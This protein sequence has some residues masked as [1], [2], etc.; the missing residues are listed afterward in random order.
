MLKLQRLPNLKAPVGLNEKIQWLKLF[1]QELSLVSL[2][3]KLV[4]REYVA[5]RV[6][7]EHL[8]KVF[9]A[10]FSLRDIEEVKLPPTYVLKANHDCG[11]VFVLGEDKMAVSGAHAKTAESALA[12]KYGGRTGEWPYLLIKPRLF[13]EDFV[14]PEGERIA[15]ADWK[16]HCA[17]GRVA[18]LQ[19]IRDRHSNPSEVLVSR[20]GSVLDFNLDPQFAPS[21]M[22]TLPG[23]WAEVIRKV[24]TVSEGWKYIRVD[25]FL[26]NEH[27]QF[28]ELTFFPFAG[29]YQGQGEQLAGRLI[30]FDINQVKPPVISSA[31]AQE[32]GRSREWLWRD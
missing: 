13:I 9:W 21:R 32:L 25:T 11:S 3:D 7:Q 29:E 4:A 27:L 2:S 8:P 5:S 31:V 26:E 1:D 14:E 19:L 12:K 28:G 17:E 15:P 30:N 23:N 16:F 18:F 22:F 6:G 24:E 20:E 10:G